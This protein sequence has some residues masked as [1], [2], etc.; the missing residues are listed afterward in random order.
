MLTILA[1]GLGAVSACAYGV[2]SKK[3]KMR[4][5]LQLF[6]CGDFVLSRKGG[7][8]YRV[9]SVEIVDSFY[10]ICEDIVKLSL[11]NYLCDLSLEACQ[12]DEGR[13]LSLLLNTMYVLAYRDIS[14]R[15]AKSVFELKL[16]QYSGYAPCMDSCIKCGRNEVLAAFDMAGGMKCTS[17]RSAWDAEVG[18]GLY[19]AM[20]YITEAGDGKMFSFTVSDK[21]E[22]ELSGISE[23]Y[24]L[25]KS[26]RSYKSLDYLKKIM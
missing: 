17:C 12:S 22:K 10:P 25:S 4:A 3:S 11:A 16:A 21:V 18:G 6:T 5:A 20:R 15:L 13:I 1:E 26:E 23:Q 7:D 19:K 14:P 2:R 24:I 8:I 9:E